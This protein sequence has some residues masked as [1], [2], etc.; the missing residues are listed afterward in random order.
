MLLLCTRQGG[1]SQTA[2]ALALW[3]AFLQPGS[4]TLLLSPTQRQS[5]ELFR[6]K[7][8]RLYYAMGRP[9]QTAQESALTMELTNGSRIVALPGDEAT[10]RGYSG[11]ALLVIDEAARVPDALYGS[12]RPMLAVSR[13]RLIALS[14]PWGKRGWFFEEWHGPRSWSRV[15]ITAP[16]CPRIDAAF[17]AEEEAALGPIWYRQEYLCS[18]EE[19]V[20]SLFRAEDLDAALANNL[21]PLFPR[22]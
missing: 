2:A 10:I 20:D 7:V 9:V 22:T 18:F 17:L 3:T 11:V 13:G 4:L 1:K 16:D 21:Q 12:V 8:K 6:D 19:T 5:G 14:T 15:R